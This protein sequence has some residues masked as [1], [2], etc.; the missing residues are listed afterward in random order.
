[1]GGDAG[2]AMLNVI[3]GVEMWRCLED[4]VKVRMEVGW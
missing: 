1:M 4:N 3:V 2:Q